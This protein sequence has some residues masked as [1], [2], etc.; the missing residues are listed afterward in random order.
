M[1]DPF[2]EHQ[3]RW[4]SQWR[5]AAIALEKVRYAELLDADLGRIALQLDDACLHAIRARSQQIT[6]GLIEQQR[7][8]MRARGL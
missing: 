2:L 4:I 7:L 5:S 6:S 3:R 1:T 8:F